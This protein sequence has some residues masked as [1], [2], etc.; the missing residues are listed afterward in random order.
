M[1]EFLSKMPQLPPVDWS[2]AA[3]H[4]TGS[5]V[6]DEIEMLE[7][8][9]ESLDQQQKKM[10]IF[11]TEIW[12]A[13]S[14]WTSWISEKPSFLLLDSYPTSSWKIF[15]YGAEEGYNPFDMT[16]FPWVVACLSSRWRAAAISC[17]QL[18]SSLLISDVPQNSVQMFGSFWEIAAHAEHQLWALGGQ[19]LLIAEWELVV[20]MLVAQCERWEG[21]TFVCF[22]RETVHR[23][24]EQ[25]KGRLSNL[26]WLCSEGAITSAYP[27]CAPQ[28][29]F[30]QSPKLEKVDII[31]NKQS[32]LPFLP[33]DQLRRLKIHLGDRPQG[34][35]EC[36]DI[37][38][39]C[40]QL[41]HLSVRCQGRKEETELPVALSSI[42]LPQ[43]LKA[44]ASD[45][46]AGVCR[47]LRI[48]SGHSSLKE[49][50]VSDFT[51][52]GDAPVVIE[53]F[54]LTP[55]LSR[56]NTYNTQIYPRNL[57]TSPCST[58]VFLT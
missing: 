19:I 17:P 14:L 45:F 11:I 23:Q 7:Q 6:K 57:R 22:L 5:Q 58:R 50:T 51:E 30:A 25:V 3:R 21:L 42:L 43:L 34:H 31:W 37:L 9:L 55:K 39:D 15:I 29:L 46:S 26:R 1:Q 49:L 48:N 33:W 24:M 40:Q 54:K 47:E 18:W 12:E 16:E 35:S 38:K 20:R 53:V 10:E 27:D 52:V 8:Q 36:L 32:G 4:S 28:D 13:R 2:F 56:F 41:Q 44:P